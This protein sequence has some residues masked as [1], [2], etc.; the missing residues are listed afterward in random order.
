MKHIPSPTAKQARRFISAA[1]LAT[2]I[3]LGTWAITHQTSQDNRINQTES[4]NVEMQDR[5]NRACRDAFAISREAG[6][7]CFERSN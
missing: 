4:E 7:A 6:Q 3:G 5:F 1:V 2:T